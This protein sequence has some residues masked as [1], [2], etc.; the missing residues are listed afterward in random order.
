MNLLSAIISGIM[1]V[2]SVSATAETDS[3]KEISTVIN[4]VEYTILVNS[5]GKTAELKSVYLPHSYA[6]A[7]VPTEISGYNITAIG[8]RAFV[9]N[10]N[11]EKITI[12]KNIK[13]IGEKAFMSCNELTEVTFSNGITAIPDDCF[14]SCPKLETVKLPTSLKTIGDE[15]FFGCVV[16]DMEIP[17]S[18]TAIGKNAV[19]MEAANHGEGS[20]AIH[21]FL[22]KGTTGSASEKYALE[23]GI[24]FIDMKNFVAGDVNNDEI[25][26]ATDASN[27]LAEYALVSTGSPAAFTKKQRIMGDMNGD[28]IVDSSDASEILAIYAKNSTGG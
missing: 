8:E 28:E 18:V 9:G 20:T 6:E 15:A 7:E 10:F 17:S 26:D 23:N 2:S 22:I 24:D 3:R 25:T 19:G 12:G 11:V 13:S 1:A 27:V 16:L 4:A 21:D 14:F 5:D